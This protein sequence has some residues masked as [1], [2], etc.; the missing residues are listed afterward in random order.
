M[1]VVTRITSVA[2]NVLIGFIK[3]FAPLAGFNYGAGNLVRVWQA[4]H[5]AMW[6]STLALFG[7]AAICLLFDYDIMTA[8]V[9]ESVEAITIGQRGIIYAVIALTTFGVQAVINNYFLAVGKA[10]QGFVLSVFFQGLL[11][12]PV[13]L[14]MKS[15]YGL[16][17]VLL[18]PLPTDVIGLLIAWVLWKREEAAVYAGKLPAFNS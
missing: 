4:T 18:A 10:K 3:G 5:K 2:S 14:I 8:F 16:E 9:P 6:W 15:I 11:Y 12:I 1:G 17:G 13:L 7:F